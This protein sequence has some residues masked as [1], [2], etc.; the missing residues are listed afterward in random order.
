MRNN[1]TKGLIIFS[2]LAVL[3]S[4]VVYFEKFVWFKDV[5]VNFIKADLSPEKV[6]EYKA[7][8]AKDLEALKIFPNQ[9]DVYLDLGNIYHS[10]GDNEK[11]IEHYMTAWKIIPDNSIPWLNSGNVYIEMGQ[12]QKAE[13]AFIKAKEIRGD[14]FL[15]YFHL[16]RLYRDFLT[17]KSGLV[18]GVFLEGLA[19]TNND[20]ELLYHFYTYLIEIEDYSDAAKYL[21]AFIAKA[22]DPQNRADAQKELER[23]RALIK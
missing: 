10:L 7:R 12:Y 1:F 17:Q 4:A 3:L 8:I 6:K 5:N 13:E 23:I 22:P 15:P 14:F 21:E 18:K 9:Y 11:A 20:Y 19:K 16:A 2:G